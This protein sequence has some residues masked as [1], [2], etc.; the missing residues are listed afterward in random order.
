MQKAITKG[1]LILSLGTTINRNL[2]PKSHYHVH[3]VTM[4]TEHSTL[5]ELKDIFLS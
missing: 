1:M 4:V 5:G 2:L 3:L